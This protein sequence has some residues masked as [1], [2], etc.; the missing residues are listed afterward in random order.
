M[1]FLE[2]I[3]E[4]SPFVFQRR[5]VGEKLQG[6]DAERAEERVRDL[7]AR[8]GLGNARFLIGWTMPLRL[9]VSCKGKKV[10][11]LDRIIVL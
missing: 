8:H 9:T 11:E 7:P 4:E 5:M 2:S 1:L 3:A 10:G 6:S